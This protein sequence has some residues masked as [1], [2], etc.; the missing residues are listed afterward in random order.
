MLPTYTAALLTCGAAV[1]CK[2]RLSDPKR[3]C[4]DGCCSDGTVMLRGMVIDSA[5]IGRLAGGGGGGCD[6]DMGVLGM[7]FCVDGGECCCGCRSGGCACTHELCQLQENQSGAWL[8]KNKMTMM[9][10]QV[11]LGKLVCT[12]D[13]RTGYTRQAGLYR[14]TCCCKLPS[15]SCRYCAD[16]CSLAA[17]TRRGWLGSG[18][19]VFLSSEAAAIVSLLGGKVMVEGGVRA[20]VISM[21]GVPKPDQGASGCRLLMVDPMSPGGIN[22]AAGVLGSVVRCIEGGGACCGTDLYSWAD[23]RSRG[24]V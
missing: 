5:P 4:G 16:G 13:V 7:E 12:H 18:G 6:D 22:N 11:T 24:S 1:C 9:C 15:A 17:G 10:A 8:T 14:N 3:S 23:S 19:M 21:A 20:V 2:L